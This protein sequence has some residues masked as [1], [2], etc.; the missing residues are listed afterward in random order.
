MTA[1]TISYTASPCLEEF[2][3][4]DAFVRGVR[5]PIG[6]GKSTGMCIELFRRMREQ[7]PGAD[8]MRRTRWAVIRNTNSQLETTTVKTWLDWFPEHL[9]GKFVRRYP[10]CHYVE[11]DDVRAEVWFLALDKPEDIKKLLS[12]E[13]TGIWVNEAREVPLD[14]VHAASGRVGR[15]PS[16]REGGPT[17][18]GI[19]MDTNPPDDEHWWSVMEGSTPM[20]DDWQQP[21]D[22]EFFI[23]PPAMFEKQVD[24]KVVWELN[25]QAENLNNLRPGYYEQFIQGKPN[26]YIR[27]YVGNKLGTTVEGMPVYKDEWNEDLHL[28][29]APLVWIPGRKIYIGLDFGRTPA[30]CFSQMTPRGQWQDLHE[31]VTEGMGAPTFAKLLKAE[32]RTNFPEA[33]F[34]VYGDPSGNDPKETSEKTYFQILDA[35]GIR[36]RPAPA[37][38]LLIRKE[39]GAAPLT[40]MIDGAP[41]YLLSP[42]CKYIRK[43]FNGQFRYKKLNTSGTTRYSEEYDKNIYSHIHEARQYAYCG[44]GE[45]KGLIGKSTGRNRS[46]KPHRAKTNF[47]PLESR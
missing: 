20:P 5:G 19:I 27:V 45:A 34:E 17:W 42:K 38:N 14:V 16:M 44:G 4:S 36:V 22:W 25:P 13:L 18:C 41:G 31:L 8:S 6:S 21:D 30:A 32:M 43:G 23:Q 15:Y 35:E 2:H 40:R 12:L 39:A 29:K 37:Q 26:H 9:F 28:A 10:M 7:R 1:A 47:N 3:L 24:G 33:Q 46:S 11:Y